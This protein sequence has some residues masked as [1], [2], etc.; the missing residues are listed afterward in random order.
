MAHIFDE[1]LAQHTINN[2]VCSA[3]WGHLISFHEPE[4]MTRVE[5]HRCGTETPG[6]VTKYYSERRQAESTADKMDVLHNLRGIIPN[7]NEGKSTDDLLEELG[8]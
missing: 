6:F 7:P 1:H 8:F 2:Y 5:C 3:C 4:R